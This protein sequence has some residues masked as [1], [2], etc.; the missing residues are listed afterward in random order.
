PCE[1]Y[2]LSLHDA[3]PIFAHPIAGHGAGLVGRCDPQVVDADAEPPEVAEAGDIAQRSRR[4]GH[5]EAGRALK[6]N[7]AAVQPD[8]HRP[9]LRSEEHT[10]ELQSRENLV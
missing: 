1:L 6:Q 5:V 9:G 2:T 4:G 3:L 8:A 7:W 10:S